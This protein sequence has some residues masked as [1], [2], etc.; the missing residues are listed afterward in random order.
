VSRRRAAPS[1]TAERGGP[2][3][4]DEPA[5]GGKHRPIEYLSPDQ[6]VQA[7]ERV[8]KL[9]KRPPPWEIDTPT[10]QRRLQRERE[11][12][13]SARRDQGGAAPDRAGPD[14]I[15][16]NGQDRGHRHERELTPEELAN[17][18]ELAKAGVL[19]TP[20]EAKSHRQYGHGHTIRDH[21]PR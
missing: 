2:L 12:A 8:G 21:R 11:A 13:A 17:V 15:Q 16:G 20:A 3:Q 14:L 9:K 1:I 6:A 4:H 5:H 7:I 18:Q 19:L 10:S